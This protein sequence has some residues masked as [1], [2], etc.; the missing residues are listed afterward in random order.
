[1]L[2]LLKT[3][4]SAQK[5]QQ[6]QQDLKPFLEALAQDKNFCSAVLEGTN[7]ETI[8]NSQAFSQVFAPQ[9]LYPLNQATQ[10]F[11]QQQT[12]PPWA[13]PTHCAQQHAVAVL[14]DE[15]Q[16]TLWVFSSQL[17]ELMAYCQNHYPQLC[18][19]SMQQFLL[20]TPVSTAIAGGNLG[21][22]IIALNTNPIRQQQVF[23]RLQ[24]FKQLL[25]LY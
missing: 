2:T 17:T 14:L 23:Y 20:A 6:A 25:A 13:N 24:L 15:K 11:L 5:Q 10:Q 19:K 9:A 16:N 3:L 18:L 12:L 1:M 8:N 21:N 4:F 22:I 7:P